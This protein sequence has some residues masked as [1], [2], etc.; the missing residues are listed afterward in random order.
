MAEGKN[1]NLSG[2]YTD[3]R[4]FD[5]YS[6]ENQQYLR[7]HSQ[8]TVDGVPIDKLENKEDG[9]LGSFRKRKDSEGNTK[10]GIGRDDL[11][12]AEASASKDPNASGRGGDKS[13]SLGEK[14]KNVEG[15]NSTGG[16]FKNAVKGAEALKS[17]NIVKAA[18]ILKKGGPLVAIL[19]LILTFAGVSFL[20]QMAM[21]FSL[22]SQLQGNFDSISVSQNIR[23]RSFLRW[24]TARN[25]TVH[26]CI[27]AHYFRA[28]EFRVTNR[29]RN[30]LASHGITFED[31]DGIT[32]MKFNQD[33]QTRTIV[34]DSSQA[35]EGR[36]SFEEAFD[37]DPAFNK[38]YTE[39]SRTWRGSVGAW[40]D[41]SMDK[42][43]AK[44]GVK[45][46]VWRD[47]KSGKSPDENMD[48]MRKTVSENSDV[49]SMNGKGSSSDMETST[50]G[51]AEG[52][53]H[54]DIDDIRT[55]EVE[56]VGISRSDI[57]MDSSGRVTNTD[58]VKTK[59][60]GI[61]DSVGK[62]K[63]AIQ[64]VTGV[65]CGIADFVGAVSAMVA[66]YQTMQII[67]VASNFFEGVQKAQIGDGD[68][69]PIHELMNSLTQKSTTTYPEV[70]T[71]RQT[72]DDED[73]PEFEPDQ[74]DTVTVYG[75][76][77][78]ANAIGALY[79]GTAVDT[80]DPSVKSYNASSFSKD[81]FSSM[82][83]I[84]GVAGSA[85]DN[86][87]ISLSAV[88]SCMTARL[89]AAAAGA[90]VDA[91]MMVGCV[92][93]AGV[94]CIIDY[95]LDEGGNIAISAAFSAAIAIAVSVLV[96]HI[97]NVLTRSIA[98]DVVG[99]DLGNALVSGANIYMGRN[100]QYSGGSL[101]GKTAFT[102]Y[103]LERDRVIA[104]EARYERENLSP[105]DTSSQ[106]TFMGSLAKQL[107]TVA[108][109]S[110]SL[111]GI[112]N[113]TSTIVG[114]AVN[115]L[116]PRSSAVSAGIEAQVAT[117]N[118]EKNCP[119]L[120]EIGAVG[121][122]FCNPYIMTDTSTM[123]EHPADVINDISENDLTVDS[124]G[125]P[126]VEED[127]N[128]SK[129]IIFCGQR[130]SPFGMA[131]QNI[132][133][134]VDSTSG[135]D[136]VTSS[137]LG[138]IPV[139]GDGLDIV[140]NKQKLENFGWISGESCVIDNEPPA[141]N[142]ELFIKTP[143]WEEAKKYQR[144]IEDQRLAEAEGIIEESAVSK[145]LASYYEK[146]PIDTSFEGTLARYSGLTKEKVETTIALLETMSWLADYNPENYAPCGKNEK[147][148]REE[149]RDSLLGVKTEA[150]YSL[151]AIVDNYNYYTERRSNYSF[152]A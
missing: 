128:L 10:W 62:V 127:S 54:T 23:S 12:D 60:K 77:M 124:E 138:A 130:S 150:I 132:A 50:T 52:N 39:G 76:A 48:N 121:D 91:A 47:F 113:S 108:S 6:P 81:I 123:N 147:D 31:E 72:V 120:A 148:F 71:V 49:D 44:L 34:A 41:S 3:S 38:A 9:F 114:N 110:S 73:N 145:Y 96:P 135:L 95:F 33:G 87:N 26:D 144:F 58:G 82:N 129:Y 11:K 98:T 79:G 93:S 107:V 32:V 13:A 51:D 63:G 131:D 29:Q 70:K 61:A 69:A 68:S 90:A 20:G 55:G 137:I 4:N 118:T 117:D 78:E 35:G 8:S 14:E 100:H 15:D 17:G 86:V 139:V 37:S 152:S 42:L 67:G 125:N 57:E 25:D 92:F 53:T 27:R 136:T 149:R 143:R 84:A 24:Q 22:V 5:A 30:K 109:S 116:T 105:F 16:K 99:E 146:N 115:A 141:G 36:I 112:I 64:G 122:A 7:D 97:V 104:E 134:S 43:L 19:A 133:A 88:S 40:F 2:D 28:D 59:L 56:D 45:R 46:G 111:M 74:V 83:G 106:Y 140:S 119:E 21:P 85:L 142:S 18:G 151:R 126:V 89:A 101:G 94:G 65:Y 66:A 80:N 1:R 102:S 103:T 75:S